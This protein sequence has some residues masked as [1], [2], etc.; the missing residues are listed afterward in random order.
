MSQL[1]SHTLQLPNEGVYSPALIIPD[2]NIYQFPYK[3]RPRPYQRESLSALF[4]EGKKR[5]LAFQHRR[6]GKD[7]TAIHALHMIAM[8]HPGLYIYLLPKVKQARAVIWEGRNKSGKNLMDCIHKRFIRKDVSTTMTRYLTNGSIIRIGGSDK[9]DSWMGTNPLMV[10]LSEFSL[11]HPLAWDYFRPILTENGGVAWFT[12][13][14][15]GHN[16]AYDLYNCNLDNDSWYVCNLT[17]DHTTKLDG[18]RVIT[19]EQIEED[20]RSGMAESLIQQEYYGSFEAALPGAF[21]TE[22]MAKAKEEGRISKFNINPL[23]PVH[24]AWDI[25]M[26][27]STIILL[28]QREG[29]YYK[30]IHSI[31]GQGK[32]MHHYFEEME[33][34]QKTLG[35]HRYGM[36]YAPHDIGV[37]E[38]AAGRSR[39]DQARRVGMNFI[40]VPGLGV[41]EGIQALRYMFKHVWLHQQNCAYLIDALLSYH[42]EYDYEKKTFGDP[43][44]DWSSHYVD[45]MRMFAVGYLHT[46]DREMLSRQRTY[47]RAMPKI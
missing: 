15:R 42:S 1:C 39:I 40:Q 21:F 12:S 31:E 27:D 20:R 29:Q 9:F 30:F 23:V 11:C 44:H 41:M 18:S 17:V 10:V 43:V 47:A 16:H 5:I 28:F 8:E 32:G 2:K 35:F 4:L 33:K 46:H 6:A 19:P 38:W 34:A 45:A 26:R 14:P 13:T 36:H 22:E 25:G 37:R 3:F 7:Q 24:T